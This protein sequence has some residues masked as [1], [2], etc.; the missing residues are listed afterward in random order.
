LIVKYYNRDKIKG[1]FMSIK[2]HDNKNK[3]HSQD[4]PLMNEAKKRLKV[5]RDFKEHRNAYLI[6]NGAFC[7]IDFMKDKSLD[8]AYYLAIMWG[9]GLVFDYFDTVKKLRHRDDLE[10]EVEYLK[11][12]QKYVEDKKTE[13]SNPFSSENMSKSKEMEHAKK[14]DQ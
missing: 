11:R 2:I 1:G 4:D 9:I 12:T 7:L 3:I 5:K 8:W 13:Y 6:V 10:K 14:M